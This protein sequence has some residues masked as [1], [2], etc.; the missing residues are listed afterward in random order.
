MTS[1]ERVLARLEGK[2]VDRIPN[3]NIFMMMPA[4]QLGIPYGTYV[5]D[6][7]R[8]VDG[9]LYCR[10]Q[11]DTDCLCVI[12]DPV[13]E[14]EGMGA[15]VVVPE[16]NVP[17]CPT[18][19]VKTVADIAKV[20]VAEASSCRRMEDRLRAVEALHKESA[21][22]LPVI[23]WVEG[24]FAESCD[25]MDISR[26]MTNILDEPDAMHE[27][28]EICTQ[29]AISFALE[30]IRCGADFIG[31]GDAAAS[32]IGPAMFEEFVLPY[33]QTLFKAIHQAGAKVKLHICG[34]ITAKLPLIA[35]TG[36]DIVDCDHMVS[37]E[38]AAS[39]LPAGCVP[40]GNIDPVEFL[41]G[42]PQ[43]MEELVRQCA[44]VP[45]VMVSGGC[46]IPRDT[47]PRNVKHM[48][49]ILNSCTPV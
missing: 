27:L 1:K 38:K 31:V 43:R 45:G 7:R 12:S 24:A 26:V 18:P 36:A 8:L 33:E 15:T 19:F 29:Q 4:R 10:E 49:E 34:N 17:Y 14:T 44:A 28:L 41:S 6:H 3:L 35:Q 25:L 39:I 5:T 46:E 9:V 16:D 13:R 23:G 2:P 37:M 40:N 21:G 11:F 20:R 30:Q 42:S 32:L 47:D 22:E 48:V